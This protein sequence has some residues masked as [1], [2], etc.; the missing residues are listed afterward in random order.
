ML[1]AGRQYGLVRIHAGN[2]GAAALGRLVRLVH[3]QE[4]LRHVVRL[5]GRGAHWDRVP[6]LGEYGCVLV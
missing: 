4:D 6:D 5:H 3:E 2:Q 1:L